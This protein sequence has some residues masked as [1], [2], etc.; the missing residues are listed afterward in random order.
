MKILLLGS[1]VQS[2]EKISCYSDMQSY[3]LSQAL[4]DMGIEVFF[5]TSTIGNTEEFTQ[6]VLSSARDNNADHIIALG[7][8]FFQRN[9]H[10]IGVKIQKEFSGL[11]C[12]IHDGS[13]LDDFP[14][15]LN[16]CVKD[17]EYRYIDN[18]NNRLTRHRKANHYIGW[19][20][21]PKMFYPQ[22]K[23]NGTL[24]VFVDHSTFTDNSSDYTL[25]VLMSLSRLETDIASGKVP[26]YNALHV[27]TLSNSGLCDVD[28]T[29]AK[30]EPYNRYAVPADL[31]SSELRSS[32]IFMV[33][34]NESVGLCV[35]EAAMSGC[36]VYIPK[37]TIAIDLVSAVRCTEFTNAVDWRDVAKR[38]TPDLN[39]LYVQKYNWLNVAQNIIQGLI[40]FEKR[41]L[42]QKYRD[43]LK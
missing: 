38:I 20:A 31:F 6:S 10:E 39:S 35:L 2:R 15:D 41:E 7:V 37:G 34:H 5:H 3:Y 9:P 27:R 42:P 19:A 30:V 13:Q 14:V 40:K 17:D 29:S 36:F 11:V 25:N 16:F 43:L 32:H 12:Q 26:G 8:R 22:Q 23:E 33:T 28:L 21:D 18:E 24:R 4:R 1:N